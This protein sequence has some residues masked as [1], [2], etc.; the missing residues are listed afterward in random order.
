[1]SY[2]LYVFIFLLDTAIKK[3]TASKKTLLKAASIEKCL[4]L[5]GAFYKRS[6]L[7]ENYVFVKLCVCI[8][9]AEN[10]VTSDVNHY[11][12]SQKLHTYHFAIEPVYNAKAH[13]SF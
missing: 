7:K 1:M 10:L 6:S 3:K 8:E 4:I 13:K 9:L 11:S 5:I 2:K 12:P